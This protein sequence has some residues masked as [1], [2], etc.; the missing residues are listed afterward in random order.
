MQS[1]YA[2][3]PL[4]VSIARAIAGGVTTFPGST[5]ISCQNIVDLATMHGVLPLLS[6]RITYGTVKGICSSCESEL[7]QITRR[8]AAEQLSILNSLKKVYDSAKISGIQI[9]FLKGFPVSFLHYKHSYLRT[10]SD[11]D[12]FVCLKDVDLF[13][14][15]LTELGY[16]LS[17]TA[18]EHLFP[19][20]IVATQI[21]S[22]GTRLELDVHLKISNRAVFKN[23]LTFTECWRTRQ[24]FEVFNGQ[25][26]TLGNEQLL[27]HCCI[28]RLADSRGTRKNKLIWI[29]DIHLIVSAMTEQELFTFRALTNSKRVSALCH[30]GLMR[31]RFYF[32]T[33]FPKGYLSSFGQNERIEPSRTL[34]GAS[35]TGWL[36]SDLKFSSG[37]KE[38]SR[39]VG[40]LVKNKWLSSH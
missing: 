40:E 39:V 29:F 23:L 4:V 22:S 10:R 14:R 2:Y 11:V 27:M 8:L 38:K 26:Y 32:G 1:Q 15:L 3:S 34:V 5:K 37:I 31:S 7:R 13:L 16:K 28:H 12:I 30:D 35:K 19:G 17:H 21:L 20:Q 36:W 33:V 9:L 18:A 25:A 24:S 6:E